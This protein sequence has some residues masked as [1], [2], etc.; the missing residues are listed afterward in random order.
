MP[1]KKFTVRV[2]V[3]S[4]FLYYDIPASAEAQAIIKAEAR[5]ADDYNTNGID[6][7][8]FTGEIE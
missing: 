3:S 8:K 6:Y 7:P 2:T 4:S 1:R 5:A